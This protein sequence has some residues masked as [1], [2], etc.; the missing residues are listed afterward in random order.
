[1]KI[2]IFIAALFILSGCAEQK[3]N[4]KKEVCVNGINILSENNMYMTDICI[5]LDSKKY[6]DTCEQKIIYATSSKSIEELIPLK[7]KEKYVNELSKELDANITLKKIS[8]YQ[9]DQYSKSKT[10]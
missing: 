9:A 10:N 7:G 1:M 4:G 2:V 8:I 6:S 5:S 3:D